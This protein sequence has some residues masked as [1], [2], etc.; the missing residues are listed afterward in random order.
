MNI[1]N[2]K[3][4]LVKVDTINIHIS[5]NEKQRNSIFLGY[6]CCLVLTFILRK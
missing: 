1:D 4:E 3:I 2:S 5:N 6:E